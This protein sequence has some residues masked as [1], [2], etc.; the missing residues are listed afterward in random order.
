MGLD[1]DEAEQELKD[2]FSLAGIDRKP[3]SAE[4]QARM[5]IK[6]LGQFKQGGRYP[7]TQKQ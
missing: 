3:N 2:E 5:L 4:I 1:W 6:A 7:I